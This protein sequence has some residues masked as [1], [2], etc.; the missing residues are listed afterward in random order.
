MYTVSFIWF[1]EIYLNR[2]LTHYLSWKS[3][4]DLFV[5]SIPLSFGEITRF[6]FIAR[7][8]SIFELQSY[9]VR[10]LRFLMKPLTIDVSRINESPTLTFWNLIKKLMLLTCV[11]NNLWITY[12]N[13]PLFPTICSFMACYHKKILKVIVNTKL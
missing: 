2:L 5:L 11:Y 3:S 7:H 9:I 1:R 8:S 6:I 12:R 10:E 13:K 4:C